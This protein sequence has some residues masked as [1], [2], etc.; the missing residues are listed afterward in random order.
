[1]MRIGVL[2]PPVNVTVEPEFNRWAPAGVTI[3][4]ARMWR[5]R[6]RPV[7]Y[8]HLTLPTKA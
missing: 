3:H 7:S 4:A 8:T 1:M 6:A 2:I 5:R